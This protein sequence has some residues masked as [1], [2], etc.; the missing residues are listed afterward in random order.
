M[1]VR[2]SNMEIFRKKNKPRGYVNEDHT[3]EVQEQRKVL[4][5]F[6]KIAREQSDANV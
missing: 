3:K 5:K 6:M 2:A 1:E 4:M